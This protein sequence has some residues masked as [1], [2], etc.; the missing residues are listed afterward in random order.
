MQ[1]ETGTKLM[2][3]ALDSLPLYR[4]VLVARICTFLISPIKLPSQTQSTEYI[5][6]MQVGGLL[7]AMA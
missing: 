7:G 5:I 6:Q 2:S 1:I 4:N 3:V